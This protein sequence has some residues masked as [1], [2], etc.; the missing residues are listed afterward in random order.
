MLSFN[1]VMWHRSNRQK[2]KTEFHQNQGKSDAIT[3]RGPK[4]M[5]VR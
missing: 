1:N 3:L 5:V 4:V 2:N